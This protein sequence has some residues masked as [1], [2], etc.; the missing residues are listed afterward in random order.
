MI[1]IID[2]YINCL[3]EKNSVCVVIINVDKY[4]FVVY[5]VI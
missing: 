2:L 4:Y 1:C 3:F 5:F